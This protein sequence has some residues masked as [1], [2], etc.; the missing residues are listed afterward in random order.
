SLYEYGQTLFSKDPSKAIDLMMLSALQNNVEALKFLISYYGIDGEL[1]IFLKN[2][3]S[4]ISFDQNNIHGLQK[5]GSED[6]SFAQYQLWLL[7]INGELIT[8]PKAYVWLKKAAGNQYPDALYS[9]GILYY[10]GFIVPEQ[11]GKA[12]KLLQ[13]STELG[14]SNAQFFL[15]NL[16]K[17]KHLNKSLI[18][19]ID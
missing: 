8:K 18:D 11:R 10:Y 14:S 12:L 5:L 9:L 15:D 3:A 2:R 16:E 4:T 13:E 19:I 7:Y 17:F 6:D 1:K